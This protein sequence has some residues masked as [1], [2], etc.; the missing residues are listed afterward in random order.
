[1]GK[2]FLKYGVEV[3]YGEGIPF[4]ITFMDTAIFG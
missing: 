4:K 3:G 2:D 1:M